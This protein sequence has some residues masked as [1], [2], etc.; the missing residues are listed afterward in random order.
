MEDAATAILEFDKGVT[1]TLDT[2]WSTPGYPVEHTEVVLQG[3]SGV[4]EVNDTRLRLYLNEKSGVY[5]KGWTTWH[6]TDQ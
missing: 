5:D 3:S 6:S 2:S 4:L 1:G